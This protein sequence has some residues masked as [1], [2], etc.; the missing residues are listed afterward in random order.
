MIA[1]IWS[2]TNKLYWL[3][4]P[5]SL[6]YGLVVVIRKTCYRIGIFK[7]WRAPIPV[8]V[9]GNLSVGGNGK[10]P[11]V[12]YLVEQLRIRGYKVGVVSRG[13]G[14][15]S[16]HYPLIVNETTPAH[17]A[18]DEPVLVYQR[19]KVPFAVSP[20]RSEAIK[21]LL[22]RHKLDL[23]I[24]DDGLQHY[25][26]QRDIEIVVVDGK[27]GFGNGWYLPAGPMRELSG[28]LKSVDF[29]VV[30]GQSHQVY[31]HAYLMTLS[32]HKAINMLTGEQK[33]VTE[34]QSVCA[35]AGIGDPNRFFNMLKVLNV[36]LI[37]NV[38][39]TDHQKYS[40][41]QLSNL[42]DSSG[43]LLMTEKDAVKCVSFAQNNWWYLP[44]D[45]ILPTPF[46]ESLTHKINQLKNI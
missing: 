36:D 17:I 6:L 8:I 1:R 16:E 12:I 27:N 22:T 24:T 45:A 23:I 20:K 39:F 33:S 4:V 35:I 26:L 38:S 30:N 40:L 43:I 41:Q 3:L 31:Q 10:T 44:I 37:N 29:V 18:G 5:F 21:L 25:A 15:N 7:S 19:T 28:R 34:L 9:V 46:I 2:G 42:V 13:Y 14:G 32:P 11:L